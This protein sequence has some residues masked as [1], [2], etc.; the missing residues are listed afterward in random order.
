MAKERQRRHSQ[1]G[2]LMR[3]IMLLL[4]EYELDEVELLCTK[5]QQQFRPT[6]RSSRRRPRRRPES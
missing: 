2:Q 1:N 6:T 3:R 5:Y 4:R